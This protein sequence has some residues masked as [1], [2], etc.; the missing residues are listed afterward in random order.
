[1][2]LIDQVAVVTGA[3]RN[4]GEATAK[5][6]A[7][8]GASIAV[9]DI[10]AERAGRVA[11][12][13]R[14][15]G[16]KAEVFL[17]NVADEE[18]VISLVKDVTERF[19]KVDILVN[20]VAISDNKHV[21]DVT[22]EE[23]DRVIAVT[24]TG[25]FLMSKYFAQQMVAQGHGGNIVNVGSTS[26]FYG[27]PRAVAYTAAKAG[28]TNLSRSLAIQLAKHKIRVN[29]VVPNKIGSPVGKDTF[30]PNRPVVNL[31]DRPGVPD[32]LARAILFL[33]SPDSDFIDG[34]T[35]FVDGGVSALMPGSE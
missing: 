24:L 29:C 6:L 11:E 7:K 19:G 33:V 9:T 22:K 5:L 18:G 23:W 13:I 1:M 15:A 27:R 21:L 28:V 2:K 10:D 25:T 26:G 17:A 4:I 20:N 14:A 31:R 35:L 8:E 30:D 32:D 16:G 12:E 34:T 3:G